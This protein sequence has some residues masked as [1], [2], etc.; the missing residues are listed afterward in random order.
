MPTNVFCPCYSDFDTSHACFSTPWELK[1][2]LTA[3]LVRIAEIGVTADPYDMVSWQLAWRKSLLDFEERFAP[4]A[5]GWA[6]GASLAFWTLVEVY[7]AWRITI[8]GLLGASVDSF[9][10]RA[11]EIV[12]WGFVFLFFLIS[13]Y[14]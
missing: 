8:S 2:P 4:L 1:S 5:Q 10:G 9:I 6:Q 13:F 3:S 12:T 14:F 7:R 11:H